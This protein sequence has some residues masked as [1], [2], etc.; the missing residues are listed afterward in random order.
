MI[1]VARARARALGTLSAL[2][3]GFN[4]CILT[5]RR[6]HAQPLPLFSFFVFRCCCCVII[7]AI[8]LIKCNLLTS[9]NV[10]FHSLSLSTNSNKI[11]NF[12]FNCLVC[13]SYLFIF[14]NF[15]CEL[16]FFRC[17][18]NKNTISCT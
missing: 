18:I 8:L 1:C 12:I 5:L 7:I 13:N 3:I 15:Y 17:E 6:L 16:L 2:E 10:F 4:N 9:K 11:L 14:S